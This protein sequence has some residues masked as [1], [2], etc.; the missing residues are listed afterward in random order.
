[1]GRGYK[2]NTGHHHSITEN[3]PSLKSEYKYHHG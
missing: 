3:L 1:M 2:G